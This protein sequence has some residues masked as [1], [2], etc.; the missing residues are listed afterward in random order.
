MIPIQYNGYMDQKTTITT[1]SSPRYQPCHECL[2]AS[3]QGCTSCS[4]WWSLGVACRILREC[5][6]TPELMPVL[7][8]RKQV[9][10]NCIA[11]GTFYPS[12][13]VRQK[14]SL[15]DNKRRKLSSNRSMFKSEHFRP[16]YSTDKKLILSQPLSVPGFPLLWEFWYWRKYKLT[17]KIKSICREI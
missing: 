13:A 9:S 11:Y 3:K 5:F 7:H 1:I 15:K 12:T 14:L 8:L 17:W 2:P 4:L 10:K 16:W 6:P